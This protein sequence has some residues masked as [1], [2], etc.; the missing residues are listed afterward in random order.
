MIPDQVRRQHQ[1][2]QILVGVAGVTGAGK[3]SLLNAL[4]GIS[5]MLPSGQEQAGTAVP[6]L[7]SW[8]YDTHTDYPCRAEIHFQSLEETQIELKNMVQA[9]RA[10]H[11]ID[12]FDDEDSSQKL[13]E[14]EEADAEVNGSLDKLQHVWP[15]AGNI[16]KRLVPECNDDEQLAAVADKVL[17]SNQDA[18]KL[19][20]EGNKTMFHNSPQGLSAM[21]KGY[22]DSTSM[23]HGSGETSFAAWALI[24]EVH[25]FLREDILKNGICLVDL[26]GVE[27]D[28]E[29]RSKAAR[30]FF[31]RLGVTIIVAPIHR[32]ASE[33][34]A[35]SLLRDHQRL[36]V[37]T[38]QSNFAL[39]LSKMEDLDLN[40]ALRGLGV[41]QSDAEIQ[42]HQSAVAAANTQLRRLKTEQTQIQ[43]KLNQ[44]RR[45][46]QS[47]RRMTS[48]RSGPNAAPIRDARDMRKNCR[49]DLARVSRQMKESLSA[50]EMASAHLKLWAIVT[51]NANVRRHIQANIDTRYRQLLKDTANQTDTA[52]TTEQ[53]V[54]IMPTSAKAFWTLRNDGRCEAGM[55]SEK[56]T[57][58]PY[59][60]QWV[61]KAT[62]ERR[63][64]HLDEM[65]E[66]YATLTRGLSNWCN[67][68]T[69]EFGSKLNI[70]EVEQ[71]MKPAHREFKAVSL[72]KL[73]SSL[74]LGLIQLDLSGS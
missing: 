38:K 49:A 19:V 52:H 69:A 70:K 7:V 34:T 46:M 23:Q 36:C 10:R 61:H 27:D 2:F 41:A 54:E 21:V 51:R 9:V 5:E 30:R 35:Q 63:E 60:V 64:Q 53:A 43:R 4:L 56:H 55:P 67:T 73:L 11:E 33:K 50:I 20:K 45:T 68:V 6:C 29:A 28:V 37:R 59:V 62:A 71:A 57:G 1:E 32:A 48:G 24:R 8:N 74:K 65:L 31:N 17:Q 13:L 72:S 25:L 40:A 14:I 39:V 26:P 18:I 16:A 15:D 42:E 66:R 22:L 58:L 3:T 47:A 12:T 44:A